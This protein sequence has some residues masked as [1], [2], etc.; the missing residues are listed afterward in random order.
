MILA[1]SF[2]FTLTTAFELKY[3][4]P[5]ATFEA[6]SF[7]TWDKIKI[8]GSRRGEISIPVSEDDIITMVRLDLVGD[9]RTRGYAHGALLAPGMSEFKI[10]YTKF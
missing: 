1:V 7:T 6:S 10:F 5:P 3:S 9:S 2:L 8:K 4:E